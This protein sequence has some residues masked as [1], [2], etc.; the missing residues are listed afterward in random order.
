MDPRR[1][2]LA[3]LGRWREHELADRGER[4]LVEAIPH[5]REHARVDHAP[6]DA[7]G[8]LELDRRLALPHE[9]RNEHNTIVAILT[10]L[11]LDPDPPTIARARDPT[12]VAA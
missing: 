12:D 4:G 3:I 2:R 6:V 9:P 7:D 1:D 8:D 5:R 11:G 10:H